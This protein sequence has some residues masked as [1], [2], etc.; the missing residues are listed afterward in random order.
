MKRGALLPL[1]LLMHED[2]G[3]YAFSCPLNIYHRVAPGA[4][5]GGGDPGGPGG[6]F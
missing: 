2:T 3:E 5:P 1:I 6:P 4:D